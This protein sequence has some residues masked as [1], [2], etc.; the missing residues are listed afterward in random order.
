MKHTRGF[1]SGRMA[2]FCAAVALCPGIGFAVETGSSK[3]HLSPELRASIDNLVIL[4]GPTPAAGQSITG[5][6]DEPTDGL[7]GGA[8]RGSRMGRGV[9]TEIGN[10]PVNFPIPVLT[11]PGMILGGISGGL[12]EQV[13]EF[14][15]AMTDE[16][17]NAESRPLTNDALAMDVFWGVRS[18]S[19]LDAKVQA[20]T[21]P[22][23]GEADAV[24][25]VHLKELTIDVQESDAI[26]TTTATATLRRVSDGVDVHKSEVSYQDR[27][28]LGNWTAND[29][30][31]WRDYANFARH[32]IGREITAELFD[33]IRVQHALTPRATRSVKSVKKNDW[34]GVTKVCNPKLAWESTLAEGATYGSGGAPVDPASMTYDLEI[35]DTN[36]RVY[37]ASNIAQTEHTPTVD[38]EGRKVYRWSVR[39]RYRVGNVV[40]SGDWMRFDDGGATARGSTGKQA[41]RAPAYVYDFASLDVKCR[42]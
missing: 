19:G 35:Y 8:S 20:R 3:A 9:Q 23:P 11:L 42:K 14:R 13:Q 29:N 36:R 21:V 38:L 4:A 37:A 39:P 22:I 34:Q 5:T 10:I 30:A 2:W 26:L 7:A 28:S 32:F 41:S 40:R 31:L 12:E 15:D 18:L 16:L 17:A 27:D 1:A 6:Y 24:L 25:F 33:R